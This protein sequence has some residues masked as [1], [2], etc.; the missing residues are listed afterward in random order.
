M[1]V[2]AIRLLANDITLIMTDACMSLAERTLSLILI[3][4]GVRTD[5]CDRLAGLVIMIRTR[6]SALITR[7]A[8]VIGVTA[9]DR[10]MED[11]CKGRSAVY[12]AIMM[13]GE[14]DGLIIRRSRIGAC[15]PYNHLFPDS[16]ISLM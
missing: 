11:V 14:Y 6:L 10:L 8:R 12:G 7:L 16:N 2:M 4:Y 3:M 9:R 1:C 5:A 13:V 15:T